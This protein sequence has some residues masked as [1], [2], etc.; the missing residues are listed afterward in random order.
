MK[1]KRALYGSVSRATAKGK[2]YTTITK[3]AAGDAGVEKISDG[4]LLVAREKAPK[5]LGALRRF[6][7]NV[8]EIPVWGY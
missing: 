8:K 2:S 5:V 1:V 6:K 3:G 4:G 7:A